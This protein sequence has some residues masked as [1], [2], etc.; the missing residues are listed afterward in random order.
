L[1][2]EDDDGDGNSSFTCL[3]KCINIGSSG[4]FET[5]DKSDT[6]VIGGWGT[7]VSVFYFGETQKCRVEVAHGGEVPPS[8]AAATG[9]NTVAGTSASSTTSTKPQ[10]TGEDIAGTSASSTTSTKPQDTGEDTVAGTSASSTTS[11]KPQ[12]T[13]ED[14]VAGTSASS[15]TST[16]PQ[17]T[18]EDTI[19]T[20]NE[21]TEDPPSSQPSSEPSSQPSSQPS[22]EPSS[23]PSSQPSSSSQPSGKP[24]ECFSTQLTLTASLMRMFPSL[25]NFFLLHSNSVS[26]MPSSMPSDQPSMQPSVSAMPSDEPSISTMPSSGPSAN[27]TVSSKPSSA[28]TISTQPTLST[29]PTPSPTARKV[30]E[31]EFA[32]RDIGSVGYAGGSTTP[33]TET[34]TSSNGSPSSSQEPGIQLSP[35]AL[36][37][38]NSADGI[39]V[40][41]ACILLPLFLLT[42]TENLVP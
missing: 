37:V 1:Q 6:D 23:H 20:A 2:K 34:E 13:G 12:D 7:P 29:Y 9:A 38:E 16:K 19:D 14:T 27:P 22:S 18:G 11:T 30:F 8:Q 5:Y 3:K 10:D 4:T 15:T 35:D 26:S 42:F 32:S 24:F 33:E 21:S 39:P 28:P 17:D 31:A 40:I 41:A 36:N 25:T